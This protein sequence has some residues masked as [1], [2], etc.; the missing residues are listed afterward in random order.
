MFQM[1]ELNEKVKH[2]LINI[3]LLDTYVTIKFLLQIKTNIRISR[4]M[5]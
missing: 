5:S 1:T 4:V 3:Y 2:L